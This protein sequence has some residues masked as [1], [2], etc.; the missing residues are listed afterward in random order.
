MIELLGQTTLRVQRDGRRTA[1]PALFAIYAPG[2]GDALTVH[3][4][5]ARP[6][7]VA[8]GKGTRATGLTF[9]AKAQPGLVTAVREGDRRRVAQLV[10]RY[11]VADLR[12]AWRRR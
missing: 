12:E 11:C 3:V 6:V 10:A 5:Y 8:D 4:E 1:T 9:G 2:D 7:P